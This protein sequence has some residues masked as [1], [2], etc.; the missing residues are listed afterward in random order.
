MFWLS[1]N[2]GYAAFEVD[3][4]PSDD[5]VRQYLEKD[6]R[7]GVHYVRSAATPEREGRLRL[8]VVRIATDG[9]EAVLR[10]SVPDTLRF[11][12]GL[13]RL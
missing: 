10:L 4:D 11:L 1:V 9:D 13:R 2:G 5:E 7:L 6:V 12:L 3:D 8:P